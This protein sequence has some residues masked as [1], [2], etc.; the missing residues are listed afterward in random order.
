M[1]L[2]NWRTLI[3]NEGVRAEPTFEDGRIVLWLAVGCDAE[4]RHWER[5]STVAHAGVMAGRGLCATP[6]TSIRARQ[7]QRG[8]FAR[9]FRRAQ[10]AVGQTWV[11]PD[12]GAAEQCGDR[13]AGL[14][15]AWAEDV[16]AP[17]DEPRVRARWPQAQRLQQV[18]TNL[19]LVAGADCQG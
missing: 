1:R 4:F 2:P 12:G 18:G 15:L 3:L 9:L 8:F 10:P 7:R 16:L 13:Q 19:F 5:V 14:M 11:L 6:A 17:L